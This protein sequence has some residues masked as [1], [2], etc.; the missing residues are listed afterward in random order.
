MRKTDPKAA[1]ELVRTFS[2]HIDH[3]Y[4]MDCYLK[5][6]GL[7]ASDIDEVLLVGASTRIPKVQELVKEFF[8]KDLLFIR[9]DGFSCSRNGLC[10]MSLR[11]THIRTASTLTTPVSYTHLDVYK[12][13]LY[14]D[15]F[16]IYS[17]DT[18]IISL[19]SY[20]Y[21]HL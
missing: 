10:Q 19:T 6:A 12:R 7:N 16:F 5:D 8:G 9:N 3:G 21:H 14:T 4:G 17:D 20:P 15:R 18:F 11:R 2:Y 13:Q 1:D